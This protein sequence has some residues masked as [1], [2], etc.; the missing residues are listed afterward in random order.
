MV[1]AQE[2]PFRDWKATPARSSIDG[3]IIRSLFRDWK[4]M[5]A[6]SSIDGESIRVPLQGLEGNAC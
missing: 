4:A 6:R 5:P 1:K 3:E 2:S